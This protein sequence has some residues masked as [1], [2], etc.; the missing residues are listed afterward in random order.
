M[1]SA[2]SAASPEDRSSDSPIEVI[3]ERSVATILLVTRSRSQTP[4]FS[5]KRLWFRAS[6][7]S[8]SLKPMPILRPQVG[9]RKP[10]VPRSYP[11][12]RISTPSPC[13]ALEPSDITFPGPSSSYARKASKRFRSSLLDPESPRKVGLSDSPDMSH[14][15]R[16]APT[17][18]IS[19]IS[20]PRRQ[21]QIPS[22]SF[23]PSLPDPDL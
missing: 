11:A 14:I 12:N 19:L 7:S 17:D 23:L 21:D 10:A 18:D 20:I 16:H 6:S 22:S 9:A 4:T 13:H 15:R 5:P 3:V 1:S 2:R 8:T